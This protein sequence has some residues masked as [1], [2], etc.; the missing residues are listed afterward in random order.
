MTQGST[1]STKYKGAYEATSANS[2]C[3][4]FDFPKIGLG[5]G[6]ARPIRTSSFIPTLKSSFYFLNI[7]LSQN[8]KMTIKCKLFQIHVIRLVMGAITTL[9][10]NQK[11]RETIRNIVLIR[12]IKAR[13]SDF[14]PEQE[15]EVAD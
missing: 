12:K 2:T 7:T 13:I 5:N 1:T 15:E 10:Q 6:K 9:Q 8:N 14:V 3:S 11:D 4:G